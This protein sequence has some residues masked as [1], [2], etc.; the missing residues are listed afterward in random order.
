MGLVER[1]LNRVAPG[2]RADEM[3]TFT[4][5]APLS[6]HWR[7]ATC[8]EVDCR[9][10]AIGWDSIVD[11]ATHLGQ[12]QAHHI[13]HGAGRRYTEE[14]DPAGLTIFHFEPGQTCFNSDAHRT[15]IGRPELFI[16]SDGDWRGNPRGTPARI[17]QTP[18]DFVEEF[19]EH[20]QHIADTIERG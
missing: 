2:L 4:I 10:H 17:H 19:A 18:D 3:K 7:P 8:A 14:R 1:P 13:R 20:Q 9:H 6:T 11:E 15:L 16:V 12:F 5:K